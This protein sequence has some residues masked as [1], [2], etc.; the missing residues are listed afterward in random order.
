MLHSQT[1]VGNPKHR[2]QH[3][4]THPQTLRKMNA[5][6]EKHSTLP[7][8]PASRTGDGSTERD[9]HLPPHPKSNKTTS[10]FLFMH[11]R[12]STTGSM[13]T[14]QNR[15]R[16]GKAHHSPPRA[17]ESPRGSEQLAMTMPLQGMILSGLRA[18][19]SC[20]TLTLLLRGETCINNPVIEIRDSGQTLRS[21]GSRLKLISATITLLWEEK[22]ESLPEQ[23]VR[24]QLSSI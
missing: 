18:C 19:I 4:T 23:N 16:C 10:S 24:L 15:R 2:D 11:Q 12:P 22:M 14:V 6:K 9:L 7:T 21:H 5:V 3:Q 8:E 1:A 17:S 13:L 20:W